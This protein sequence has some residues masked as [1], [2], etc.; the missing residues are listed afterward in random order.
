ML[1]YLR[2]ANLALLDAV[3]LE[4]AAGF[5]AVT[6]ETGAGKSVLLGALSL[7]AGNRADKSVIRQGADACEVEGGLFFK[8]ARA[9]NA[10]LEA[11]ALPPCEEGALVL[12]RSLSHN[13]PPRIQVN[14]ALSTLAALQSLGEQWVDFHG[15]GEPQK[16][17]KESVQLDMLDAYGRIDLTAYR[18][19]YAALLAVR[20][21]IEETRAQ[22]KLSDDEITFYRAQMEKIDALE[23]SEESVAA[24]ERDFARLNNAQAL[25]ELSGKIEGGLSGEGGLTDTLGPLLRAGAELAHIDPSAEPLRQ[26]LES[27]GIE[28]NDLAQEFAALAGAEDLDAEAAQAVQTRMAAWLEL[29]RKYGNRPEDILQKRADWAQKIARQG[30]LDGFLEKKEAEAGALEKRLKTAA[31]AITKARAKAAQTLAQEAQ[32]RLAGLGFKKAGLSIAVIP[33]ETFGPTGDSR[34][35]ILFSPNPGT[36]PLPLR[37]IASGGETAR[38][39]L[40]LKTALADI[41]DTPLLVFD[42]VD[43]NVGGEIGGEVGKRLEA[44]SARHQVFC[45]THLPQVAARAQNHFLVSKTAGEASTSVSIVSIHTDKTARTEELARMLGDRA[46]K[47]ALAHAKELLKKD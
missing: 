19:D 4:F 41:D 10:A 45:V 22:G 31:A 24:L 43:A 20:R 23:L 37:K 36:P 7:L 18:A 13:K 17:F 21:E 44:L 11:L 47:S 9:I 15:P 33:L 14:G 2:I 42:E 35:E 30:D 5:T 26:R 34:A 46:S 6:G 40:A 1:H 39:M 25:R 38:V 32:G 28:A 8:D 29:R 27:L 16:L 12:R 3:E